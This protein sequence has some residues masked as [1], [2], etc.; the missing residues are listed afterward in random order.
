MNTLT[1][2]LA[3]IIMAIVMMSCNFDGNFGMGINGNGEV[4]TKERTL[5]GSFNSVKVSRGLDLYLTQSDTESLTVEAD[6]NLHEIITTSIENDVLLISA[7]E[8]IGRS[9]SKKIMLNFKNLHAIKSTSGSDVFST[10]TIYT[11]EI[12][13]KATS[14][15]DMELH[16]ES[17][18]ITCYSTSGSD[19]ELTGKTDNFIAE[20][21]SG[22]AIEADNM[23]TESAQIKATSGADIVVN[24][25]K[26]IAK[27]TSGGDI[28]Y[29]GNPEILEKSD[30]VSGSIK[31]Q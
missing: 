14:G 12:E 27:A 4:I 15:S 25:S 18:S 30:G 21:T 17:K 5:E 20:A 29:L 9:T 26:L 2:V 13:L 6:E 19:I 24:T 16:I 8:N 31:K 23:I 10:N 22:S 28:R 11:D 1:K 3:S 7:T